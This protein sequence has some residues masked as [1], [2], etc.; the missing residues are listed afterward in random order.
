MFCLD[1]ETSPNFPWAWLWVDN[2]WMCSSWVGLL[3]S[4]ESLHKS[5]WHVWCVACTREDCL[6]PPLGG[7]WCRESGPLARLC[8]FAYRPS[9]Q[10]CVILST[11]FCCVHSWLFPALSLKYSWVSSLLTF[12]AAGGI[13]ASQQQQVLR[14]TSSTS[15]DGRVGGSTSEQRLGSELLF[16]LL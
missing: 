5:S 14:A 9:I 13:T 10:P 8:L 4:A 3:E 2:E 11:A 12:E 6:P 7:R 1:K 16:R 15:P